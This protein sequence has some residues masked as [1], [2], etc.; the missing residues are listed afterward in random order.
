MHPS[1]GLLLARIFH[2]LSASE[3]DSMSE[4]KLRQDILIARLVAFL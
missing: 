1:V 4:Q 2:N 3:D